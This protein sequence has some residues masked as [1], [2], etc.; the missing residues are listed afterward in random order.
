MQLDSIRYGQS[1]KLDGGGTGL[2]GNGSG[3]GTHPQDNSASSGSQDEPWTS[4]NDPWAHNSGIPDATRK[5][6]RINNAASSDLLAQE[7]PASI[8]EQLQQ[9]LNQ[10]KQAY[11]D[12]KALMEKV[13]GAMIRVRRVLAPGLVLEAGGAA[14]SILRMVC[15]T[16]AE[17]HVICGKILVSFATVA[18]SVNRSF[19]KT[20]NGETMITEM[21]DVTWNGI[22]SSLAY[23][24]QELPPV[25][26]PLYC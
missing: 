2:Q 3:V 7:Q 15:D 12:V 21:G 11:K 9:F 26:L 6:T 20:A 19:L 10:Q 4:G 13:S 25:F 22:D 16:A 23:S 8:E 24:A 18:H 17:R 1:R 14:A 5:R